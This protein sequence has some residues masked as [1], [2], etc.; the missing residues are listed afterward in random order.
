[1]VCNNKVEDYVAGIIDLIRDD[2]KLDELRSNCLE[3][4]K[5]YTI[6][7]MA[8]N[9]HDGVMKALNEIKPRV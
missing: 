9:F 8:S 5:R 1:M 2:F 7:V 4:S 6:E 3:D